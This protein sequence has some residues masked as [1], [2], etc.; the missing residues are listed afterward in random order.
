VKQYLDLVQ[1]VLEHGQRKVNRTGVDTL[2]CFSY[3]Y[4][5]DISEKFPL[6][7]TKDLSGGPWNSLVHELIWYL[8]GQHH[9]RE[10]E[11]HSKIWSSWADENRDLETAYGRFWRRFP[12][13]GV[14]DRLQGEAWPGY[15]AMQLYVHEEERENF[16][17]ALTLDQIAYILHTLVKEPDSRR[18]VLTAWHP[19]NA[20]VS[21]L[22]PCHF[23]AVFSVTDLG[24]ETPTLN[25]HLTQR[26]GEIGLGIPFNL[27]CYSA[28]TYL[29]AEVAGMKPGCF[30][31]TIV[32]AHIYCGE[33][34]DDPYSHVK[35]LK[36]QLAREPRE[37]PTLS[38]PKFD[39]VVSD[40]EDHLRQGLAYLE[41][42]KFQDF[43]L[44]GY[45]PHP[46]I[47]MK[48]AV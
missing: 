5:A 30:G 48:V 27:A 11:K 44:S 19:A 16:R 12:I 41:A 24:E 40:H 43:K 26:S 13:P 6:I 45:D 21:R 15:D 7:T 2:S 32:D 46:R 8:S 3:H 1:H 4:T 20:V 25:C 39:T 36:T 31:H 33:N 34:E 18:M 35:A 37:L 28:L 9:I 42:L 47:K 23:S 29:L 14:E 22:P 38:I 17:F 10:F